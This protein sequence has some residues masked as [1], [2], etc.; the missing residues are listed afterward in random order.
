MEVEFE[1]HRVMQGIHVDAVQT[2]LTHNLKQEP[3]HPRKQSLNPFLLHFP[4]NPIKLH[5]SI[6]TKTIILI[7]EFNEVLPEIIQ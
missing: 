7:I 2:S 4:A 3:Q 6:E 5:L 1:D